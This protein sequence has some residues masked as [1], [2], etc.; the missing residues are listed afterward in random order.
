M[1]FSNMSNSY[2]LRSPSIEVSTCKLYSLR[3]YRVVVLVLVTEI[4]AGEVDYRDLI[5]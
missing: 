5:N 3:A 4:A 2:S 1:P